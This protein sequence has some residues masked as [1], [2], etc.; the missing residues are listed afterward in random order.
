MRYPLRLAENTLDS[1]IYIADA[2]H[3]IVA[4]VLNA[5]DIEFANDI[6]AVLNSWIRQI[7]SIMK[8]A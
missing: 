6:I 1:T 2:D 3:R 4:H 8:A 7:K 5:K